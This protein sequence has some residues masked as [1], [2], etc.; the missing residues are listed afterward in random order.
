MVADRAA[1]GSVALRMDA[2]AQDAL[3]VRA[4]QLAAVSRAPAAAL[5]RERAGLHQTLREIRAAATRGIDV[6]DGAVAV[7]G[8]G[9]VPLADAVE[10]LT[11]GRFRLL[12]RRADVVKLGG[13]RAS[14]ADL[15]RLLADIEGVQD[16]VFVA[17]ED[18]ESNPAARLTAYV[19]APG[20]TTEEILAALR[21]YTGAVVLVSHDEGAVEAL[22]PER[23]VLLPDG[24][25]DLWNPSYL[26]LVTLA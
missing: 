24:D 25:E 14:L 17:P 1:L 19:V 9:E 21:S 7:P 2:R 11:E 26:D 15:N 13:R 3:R 4:R 8:L 23:V 10:P 16:G 22:Q 18:L 12:G 6:R 20:R 5:A